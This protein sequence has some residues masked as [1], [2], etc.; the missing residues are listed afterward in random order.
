MLTISSWWFQHRSTQNLTVEKIDSVR[1]NCNALFMFFESNQLFSQGE[2]KFIHHSV[3]SPA[4][5]NKIQKLEV[6]KLKF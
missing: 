6:S 5:T 4:K 1:K 2:T 3:I